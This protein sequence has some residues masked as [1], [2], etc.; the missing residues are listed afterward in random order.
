MYTKKINIYNYQQ[1]HYDHHRHGWS[2]AIQQLN[3]LHK[4]DGIIFESICDTI[5]E[6]KFKNKQKILNKNKWI[7]VIHSTIKTNNVFEE[8]LNIDYV[9]KNIKKYDIL[10][11]CAGIYVLSE[12]SKKYLNNRYP[13]LH[14]NKVYHPTNFNI[15]TFNHNEYIKNKNKSIIHLGVFLRKFSS[16][17]RLK[18]RIHNKIAM[19]SNNYW[20]EKYSKDVLY[21]L[22]YKYIKEI[23]KIN[24]FY[25]RL[26]NNEYDKLLSKNIVF[27]D[28][29]DSSANNSVIECISRN[30]PLLINKHPAVVEY[31]GDDYPFYFDNLEEA[32]N[33]ADDIELILSTHEYLKNKDKSFLSYKYF[34]DSFYNSSIYQNL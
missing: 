6:I 14:V 27:I 21:N 8:A 16:F 25:N 26:E 18:T 23:S 11:T 2:E 4:D 17:V 28:L 30:T 1:D 15:L 12:Y 5:H 10:N 13:F 9:I 31:L 7:G 33:K 22:T 29:Y 34:L 3:P 32:N 24:F 19:V 20:Y